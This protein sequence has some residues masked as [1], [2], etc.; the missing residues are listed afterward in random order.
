MAIELES[1]EK[2]IEDTVDRRHDD[3]WR[4]A[5]QLMT[6]PFRSNAF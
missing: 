4:D 2:S 5:D 1:V 3:R 6:L